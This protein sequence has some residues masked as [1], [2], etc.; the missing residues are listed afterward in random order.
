LEGRVKPV[1]AFRDDHG[2]VC[3]H[4]VYSISLGGYSREIEGVACRELDGSWS[5]AC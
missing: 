2:R 5:L 1:S 4:L 3:R